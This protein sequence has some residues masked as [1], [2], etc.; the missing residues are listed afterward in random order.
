M[1][2]DYYISRSKMPAGAQPSAPVF[3]RLEDE[4]PMPYGKHKGKTMMEVPP[5]YLLYIWDV[6]DGLWLD[7]PYLGKSAKQVR[8]YIERSFEILETECPDFNVKH[9]PKKMERLRIP[10]PFTAKTSDPF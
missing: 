8:A 3:E 9:H 2:R 6:D 1:A 5:E 4:S 7:G 10:K